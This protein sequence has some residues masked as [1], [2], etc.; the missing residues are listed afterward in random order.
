MDG[1]REEEE[2]EDVNGSAINGN[3]RVRGDEK[4]M[5][6]WVFVECLGNWEE[7]EAKC[8]AKELKMESFERGG[9]LGFIWIKF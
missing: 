4:D 2:E 7:N 8:K 3:F 6:E 1:V 5:R 9:N